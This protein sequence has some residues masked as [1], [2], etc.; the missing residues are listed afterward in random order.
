MGQKV[1]PTG[2]RLQIQ[3]TWKSR[4]FANKAN[5]R[6]FLLE[7]VKLREALMARLKIAGVNRVDIERSLKSM[8]ITLFVTRPGIVIGRGGTGME[9]LKKFVLQTLGVGMNN[10]QAPKIDIRVE[11]VKSPDLSAYLVAT[12]IAEQLEKRMP[13]RRVVN[14]ALERVMQSGAKG[15]KVVLAGRIA[16]AEISRKEKFHLGSIPLQTLRANIDYAQVPA[17]TRSGY[18]G[19][20]TWIYKG[21]KS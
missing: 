4:W 6:R 18:V 14:K 3:D 15:A 5:Y 1:N 13:H 21:D 8:R 12:R 16:G 19:V 20:K 10:S 11:E 7:D 17:L 2:V 9:D